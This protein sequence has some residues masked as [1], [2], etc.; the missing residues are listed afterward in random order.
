MP[1]R[2]LGAGLVLLAVVV[3]VVFAFR[4]P[5]ARALVAATIDVASGSRVAFDTFA[6][7]GDTVDAA[8]VRFTR[9]KS[10]AV[11]VPRVVVR[12]RLHDAIFGGAHRYGLVSIDLERPSIRLTRQ[13]D[14]SFDVGGSTATGS[15]PSAAGQAPLVTSIA[16]QDGTLALLDPGRTLAS[17]RE[18]DLAQIDLRANV[19]SAASTTYRVAARVP[20]DAP[21]R[22]SAAGRIDASG[23][24]VQR[25]R[26]GGVAI[27]PFINYFI[28]TS[29]AQIFAGRLYEG[30]VTIYSFGSGTHVS[31]SARIA[32]AAMSVP[33]ILPP[34]SDMSG[35]IDFYDN[36]IS[37]S[38]LH[39]RIGPLHAIAAGGLYGFDR[40]S[41]AFRMGI[42]AANVPLERARALF[43]F[44]RTLPIAGAARIETFLEGPAPRPVV[45][46]RVTAP[47]LSYAG[48]PATALD[49]RALLHGSVVS[50]ADTHA[51]YDGLDV[52]A[53]GTI[54]TGDVA[55]IDLLAIVDGPAARVPYAAQLAPN[56][57]VHVVG[58]L[59]GDGLKLDARGELFGDSPP[60][61]RDGTTLQA[62][63]HV[64]PLGEGT[65]GPVLATR[66]DGATLA[67]TFYLDRIRSDSAFWLDAHGYTFASLARAPHFP[68][69]AL[70][71]PDFD[72]KLDG[73]IAGFGPPSDFR[74]A[75]RVR[76]SG[77]RVAH[78]PI[79]SVAGDV[80]GHFG[81]MRIGRATAS[82]AW[83]T[84]TG[85]GAYVGTRLVMT[86]D[87]RGSFEKLKTFT[88]DLGAHGPVSGPIAL[89]IDP[90]ATV[91]QSRGADSRGASVRGVP[92][93]RLSGTLAIA[94]NHLRLYAINAR[95]ASGT[96][97]AA[98]TLATTTSR[99]AAAGVS[100]IGVSVGDADA[101]RLHAIAPVD[102]GGT[103]A[104][105]GRFVNDGAGTRYDG[106]VAIG[107][108][109]F[110]RVP[111]S[112][113]GDIGLA[114]T[115]LGFSHTTALA[116]EAV[117]SL[118]GSMTSL[119]TK[120]PTFDATIALSE[121]A[122]APLVSSVQPGRH[123][124]AGTV[125]GT[126][127]VRGSSGD[128]AVSG[129][130]SMPEGSYDGLAF[131]D[132]YAHVEIAPGG[133]GAQD[134]T[135]TVGSTVTHFGGFFHGGDGGFHIEA[136][137]A[138]LSD[139]NDLFDTGDTLGGRGHVDGRFVMARGA[140][141]SSAD[142]GIASLKYRTFALGDAIAHWDSRGSSVTGNAAFG[143][144]SGRLET[145]GT[146][147]LATHAPLD[148]L[149]ARS[150]FS[151]DAHL[152]GLDLGVW[153]PA[154]GYQLPVTGRVDADAT[155]AGL[156]RNPD[157]RTTA[158]LAN[159]SIGKLPV[160]RFAIVASSTLSRTTLQSIDLEVPSLS[161]TGSGSFGLG[162]K[163]PVALR[164]HAKSPSVG[165][166]AGTLFGAK[167]PV[168]G[169]GEADVTIDGTRASPRVAGGFDLETAALRGIA[170]PRALGEFTI[171]GR[172][173]VLSD[174][175]VGFTTGTLYVAGSLPLQLSPF[176]LG[177]ARAPVELDLIARS[178]DLADFSPLFPT[179]STLKGTLAG[180]V[181]VSG[182]ASAPQIN[183]SLALANGAAITSLETVPITD[184]RGTLAF[185]GTNVMLRDFHAAAGGGALDVSGS[186]TLADLMNLGSDAKYR[187]D[188]TARAL[189]LSLPAY[190]SGQVDG[191]LALRHA[192]GTPRTLGGK[193]A[194]SDAT[195]P[196]AALLIA[197]ASGSDEL[198]AR[199]VVAAA[200]PDANSLALDLDVAA[201]RNVR[202]RSANVDLG[203]RGALHVGGTLAAPA[204]DGGF[205]STGGTL[206]YFNTV[207]R[208]S[209]GRVS[210]APDRGVI[211]DLTAHAETHVID[212]DPNT[213]R[214]IA[215]TADVT[216]DIKGP[217]TGLSI[218]LTSD[219]SYDREQ[220]LGLLLNAP[221][222]GATNLFDTP[223]QATLYGSNSPGAL[224][225]DI[226][227]S[228]FNNGS[229]TVAQE[230]FGVA[231]AQFT[232]TLLAPAETTFA[233]AVGLTNFNVNVDLTG[234]VG[235]QARKVLGKEV[236]AVYGTTIG[237]PYRQSFGFE[238]KP[239][240]V[241]AA[242][243]TVFQT[244]GNSGLTSLN[245]GTL[246]P[247]FGSTR[248]TAAE[249]SSGTIG[250]S[251]SLQRL[252]P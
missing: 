88:G 55:H 212:P 114:G 158:T 238:L 91:V 64:D 130:L 153:L 219:P 58:R 133:I 100:G 78:L 29:S 83:G 164:L 172:D 151:G 209:D 245:P 170:I 104:T 43:A 137:Q 140:V 214:N 108:A 113:S 155:I 248:L 160:D 249:P 77:L 102:G 111:I 24:A 35:R 180:R 82:G 129:N 216:L 161:L 194:L 10:L 224:P 52:A 39:A 134:G 176:A 93:D 96:F 44:S 251:L 12:Y 38:L 178:I 73:S 84:L 244:F 213:V 81:D 63:F 243:V 138:D 116:G 47:S 192:R 123:D 69:L 48:F 3:A 205:D 66:S 187:F 202:V 191:T 94:K 144:P 156:L 25:V 145:A 185:E 149:L 95:V 234:N 40:S 51:R 136:P 157:V 118:D 242:Q 147:D 60:G 190:G 5:L 46:T 240:D 11:D 79:G 112:G 21:A 45:I 26:A 85:S 120:H 8:N 222:L 28:N 173:L 139:F 229:T 23:F 70:S 17:S 57:R 166:F 122:L 121:T 143:G 80:T 236:S 201:E 168:S 76:A 115:R 125:A 165:A 42:A 103:I 119:G 31:G 75:G 206:T 195:I 210:F 131:R 128:L 90:A 126:F 9:G 2:R 56:A 19:N 252:F 183:G 184:L 1:R 186:A 27:L 98:G 207:F 250:F 159:G 127:H 228:R 218:G 237:Y 233:N 197:G 203:A 59:A 7:D 196:F 199:P 141:R 53:G 162:A 132:A 174:V 107:R 235:L 14:G 225:H 124:L 37:T 223:G 33:G 13:P 97:V 15:T 67:G 193:L 182:T 231:N 101:A 148:T 62:F 200:A 30:D 18:L 152:R 175:E 154:L 110:Q 86:G 208:V 99:A 36:G 105:I 32:G 232:R 146:L 169:T 135:I 247:G 109:K 198:S 49:A 50:I 188:A 72:A 217:V 167:F 215:G 246:S 106:G 54:A 189:R 142:I 181:D 68:G 227:G 171:R 211:P 177:P 6:I 117:A 34:A 179:G 89:T 20:D 163:D 241:T 16:L 41:P 92:I 239:N 204:L 4:A 221:A 61:V 150:R 65:F 22:L 74:I 71:A 230:A 226:A 87:Y 220:I